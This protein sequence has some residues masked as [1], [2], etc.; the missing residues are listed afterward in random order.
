[1]PL[2]YKVCEHKK[3]KHEYIEITGFEGSVKD[4]VIPESIDGIRVEAVGNHSFA[5]RLDIESVSL[6]DTIT[7]LF[8][9]AFFN[10]KKLKK[11]TLSDSV[12]DY[13]DGVC[14][15]CDSLKDIDITVKKSWYE[16]V[17]MFLADSD[18]TLR[19]LLKIFS[20]DAE[21][22]EIL[23]KGAVS[24]NNR[25]SLTTACL[26][27]P[28]YVYDFNENTMA[29]TIQFSIA[30]SGMFYRECVDRRSINYREYD[31]LF[32]KAVIDGN[33][34]SEDIALGRLLFPVELTDAARQVYENY[35]KLNTGSILKRLVEESSLEHGAKDIMKELLSLG[36]LESVGIDEAIRFASAGGF[37]EAC[38]ILMD[39]SRQSTASAE[40]F[41][42]F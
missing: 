8:G 14:R 40:E 3:D 24:D 12:I 18:R 2:L 26:T 27:F 1:M 16:V 25:L 36:I 42:F 23:D 4:L 15:Q 5:G 33:A 30:G 41:T 7:T 32:E 34:V 31:K 35:V 39:G 22:K 17:R 29:R 37:S 11:I 20:S 28:E 13:Y 19:F 10:C 6:P 38:A 21:D 9:F